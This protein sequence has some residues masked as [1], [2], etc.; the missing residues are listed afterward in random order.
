MLYAPLLTDA[1]PDSV[2]SLV[3]IYNICMQA[4]SQKTYIYMCLM[5]NFLP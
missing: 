3:S 5:F 4:F 2:R 1:A